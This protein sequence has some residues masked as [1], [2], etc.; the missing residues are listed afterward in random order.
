VSQP[1]DDGPGV[2]VSRDESPVL[3]AVVCGSPAAGHVGELVEIA[4]GVG[5]Q[6]C[7]IATPDGRKFIDAPAVAALTG[8]PVRSEYKLPGDL[9]VLPPADAIVVAPATVNT[10]N[11]WACGIADTLAL[12][13]LIEGHG[14]GVP[15][16]AMPY[17]N[18]AMAAHP[19]FRQSL[20]RLR[21]WGVRV[22]FGEG[23]VRLPP[24][25]AAANEAGT[26][27]WALVVA[28]VGPPRSA[29]PVTDSGDDAD[30]GRLGFVSR[31]LSGRARRLGPAPP[32]TP[33]PAPAILR[34]S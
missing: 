32:M 12:G 34:M 8:H 5:W 4:H 19:S 17:T 7:V 23:V 6:V 27:P 28:A 20:R 30:G 14:L 21:A 18:T 13:M 10:I 24:P 26:F 9:D 16:A 33:R 15:I 22:L 25:G 2:P 1:R 11:K 31:S 3:Y 29:R